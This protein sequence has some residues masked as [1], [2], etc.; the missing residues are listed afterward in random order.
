MSAR[1]RLT[2]ACGAIGLAALL[3]AGCAAPFDEETEVSDPGADV[4]VIDSANLGALM[5][6]LSDPE[7]AV[8][9]F[10]Q[11]L[12]REPDRLDLKRGYALSLAR[13]RRYNDAVRLFEELERD[14]A[15][16]D[17]IRVEHAHA[18]ARLERWTEAENQMALVSGAQQSPRRHLIDAMLADH[19]ADWPGADGAYERARALSPNPATILN[20]WGVSRMSR[21]E[22]DA[23]QKTFEEA[24]AHNPRLFSIKNNLAVSRALQGE[25]RLPL[26]TMSEE[27]RATM[28]HNVGVI[29]LR[30]GD[31]EQAKGL[32]T[33]AVETH[34]RYYAAA[35]EKLA[36]LE[37]NVVN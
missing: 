14:G 22:Y 26:V 3:A 9:Y 34:P 4:D 6:T 2:R 25:Y 15:S 37:A 13:A 18:L 32:F 20:N 33:M 24:I 23:A 16:D 31:G 35:A 28:L 11:A 7:D 1:Y 17:A 30:R 27:E 12:D 36:A 8:S 5:L 10:Q 29:A 19:R 21:G